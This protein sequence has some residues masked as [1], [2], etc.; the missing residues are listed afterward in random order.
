MPLS[1]NSLNLIVDQIDKRFDSLQADITA[2]SANISTMRTD[3]SDIQV[4]QSRMCTQLGTL[5]K[6]VQ[7]NG[8][9]EG[10]AAIRRKI[11][12]LWFIGK[13]LLWI[14]GLSVSVGGTVVGILFKLKSGDG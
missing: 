6:E 2:V 9:G 5:A 13:L 8:T 7:G 3:I 12:T 4:S 10:L 11:D 1:D 14:I